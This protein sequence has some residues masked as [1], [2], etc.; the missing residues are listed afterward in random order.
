MKAPAAWKAE[1]GFGDN[2]A[3]AFDES[4]RCFE[5]FDLNNRQ[6][7]ARSFFGIGLKPKVYVSGHR[8]R[9]C[10]AKI[11]HRKAERV[12]VKRFCGAGG[13]DR[14]LDKTDSI[15]HAGTSVAF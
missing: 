15:S 6:G 5:R 1:S 8:A 10:R 4:F 13:S 3:R 14:K 7:S 2:S 9:I 11:S 12:R